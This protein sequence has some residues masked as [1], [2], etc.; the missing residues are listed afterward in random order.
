M[1]ELWALNAIGVREVHL[2]AQVRLFND[3][4]EDI[5]RLSSSIRED[6]VFPSL[7][8]DRWTVVSSLFASSTSILTLKLSFSL[9]I[10]LF[11]I[12]VP[13]LPWSILLFSISL[14]ARTILLQL[15]VGLFCDTITSVWDLKGSTK[16]ILLESVKKSVTM[17]LT[18]LVPPLIMPW[19]M[20]YPPRPIIPTPTAAGLTPMNPTD[21]LW[22]WVSVFGSLLTSTFLFE[23]L[24]LS[25]Y[26]SELWYAESLT[27]DA[28]LFFPSEFYSSTCVVLLMLCSF[29][30]SSSAFKSVTVWFFLSFFI[31]P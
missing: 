25:S 6:S 14:D 11:T 1:Y 8:G 5:S 7:V 20:P 30:A 9:Q 18:M 26:S 28:S 10:F 31:V 23:S 24:I 19:V 4:R 12:G 29:H 17:S 15:S 2:F 3:F 16:N 22:R 21:V 27:V 13:I